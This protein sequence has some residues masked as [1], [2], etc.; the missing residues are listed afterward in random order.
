MIFVT[1]VELLHWQK[2]KIREKIIYLTPLII[3]S[4]HENFVIHFFILWVIFYI[5]EK[6]LL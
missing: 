2:K 6:F 3:Q 4:T 5:I 1:N